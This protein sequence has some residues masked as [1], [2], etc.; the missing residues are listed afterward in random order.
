MDLTCPFCG[1][2]VSVPE[3]AEKYSLHLCG[4]CGQES[5]FVGTELIEP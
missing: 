2:P 4:G 3:D 5:E 1:E